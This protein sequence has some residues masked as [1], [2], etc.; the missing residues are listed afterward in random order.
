MGSM[1]M[2]RNISGLR[3]VFFKSGRYTVEY[4]GY[5]FLGMPVIGK[6]VSDVDECYV[7]RC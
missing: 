7:H 5:G 6:V 1:N 4:L 2:R 3:N